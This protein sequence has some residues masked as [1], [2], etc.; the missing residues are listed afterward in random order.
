[1]ETI[2]TFARQL[3]KYKRE[4]ILSP[5]LTAVEVILDVLIPYV[6]ARLIDQGIQGRNMAAVWK[7]GGIMFGLGM[8]SL[9]AGV[10]AGRLA[11]T[12]ST[13]FAANLRAAMYR[14]IQK[15]SLEIY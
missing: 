15:Y 9:V 11:A 2:K 8:L 3:G 10:I 14:K 13:G 4:T 12:A 7:Y 6:I 5:A 1:M